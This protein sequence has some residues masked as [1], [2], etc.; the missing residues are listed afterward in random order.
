MA[1]LIS[2]V[3]FIAGIFSKG[4]IDTNTMFIVSGLF[5]IAAAVEGKK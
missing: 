3:F 4:S 2:L 5:A 1:F